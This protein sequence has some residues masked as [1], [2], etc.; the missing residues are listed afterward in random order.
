MRVNL[1]GVETEGE[2]AG[3]DSDGALRLMTSKGEKLVTAGD[4]FFAS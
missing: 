4:V 1:N 2:Y 3:L